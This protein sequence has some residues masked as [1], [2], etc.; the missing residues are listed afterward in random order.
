MVARSLCLSLRFNGTFTQV[1]LS[2]ARLLSWTSA[3][4]RLHSSNR[5]IYFPYPTASA[6][7]PPAP[8][9]LPF[10]YLSSSL[11]TPPLVTR[12]ESVYSKGKIMSEL[13]LT[14]NIVV[15]QF[16]DST[17]SVW[18]VLDVGLVSYLVAALEGAFFCLRLR[19]VWSAALQ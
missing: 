17:K 2:P 8:V 6:L 16:T 1:S 19:W 7:P 9:L 18:S 3:P 11:R 12:A 5:P 4:I 13:S 14:K 10:F 15:N